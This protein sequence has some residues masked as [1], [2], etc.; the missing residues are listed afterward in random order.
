MRHFR[1]GEALGMASAPQRYLLEV[2]RMR[3]EPRKLLTDVFCT[4]RLD[5]QRDV[6]PDFT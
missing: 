4:A 3:G 1:M 2:S 5:V 6:F